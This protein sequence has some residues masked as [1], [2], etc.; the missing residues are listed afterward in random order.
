MKLTIPLEI[1]KTF[2][3]FE[4]KRKA[5]FKYKMTALYVVYL[6]STDQFPYKCSEAIMCVTV[7]REVQTSFTCGQP[8]QIR[9]YI[10]DC[11]CP[12]KGKTKQMGS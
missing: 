11:S 5:C 1:M 7:D 2:D 4:K 8:F 12:F 3:I 10:I 9:N 6:F